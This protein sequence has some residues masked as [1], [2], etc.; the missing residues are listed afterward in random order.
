[1][2]PLVEAVAC[3]PASWSRRLA[4]TIRWR[5]L[6][7]VTTSRVLRSTW[8]YVDRID[9]FLAL[10]AALRARDAPAEHPGRR[11]V[12]HGQALPR[13]SW[14]AAGVGVV[15]TR[16]VEPGA[17]DR[18]RAA[19]VPRRRG[20]RVHRRRGDGIRGVRDQAVDRRG[21]ARRGALPAH[22]RGCGASRT[23][24]ASSSPSVA[25]R[26][27]NPTWTAWTSPARPPSSISAGRQATRSARGRSC[28][29]AAISSRAS[30]RPSRS[31]SAQ[32]GRGR[33]RLAADAYAAIPFDAP[34]YARI[35]MIRERAGGRRRARARTDRAVAVPGARAGQRRPPRAARCSRVR[36]TCVRTSPR[37]TAGPRPRRSCTAARC[38]VCRPCARRGSRR[39]RSG[40]G[41]S[42][43]FTVD[44]ST[45]SQPNGGSSYVAPRLNMWLVNVL[46]SLSR[47]RKFCAFARGNRS[48]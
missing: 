48:E 1:M 10:G 18:V 28:A 17:D 25:A 14:R 40:C 32:P 20:C 30:S 9:D 23:W 5:R 46:S 44:R 41:R 11:R 45:S 47:P 19:G 34:L 21:V 31:A 26:C 15:P 3:V 24:R 16:F 29:S 38:R 27:C 22:G 4:G 33:G 42:S 8:N 13:R 37:R 43:R 2:P 6:V 36:R 35:D 12:E 7:A 39:S